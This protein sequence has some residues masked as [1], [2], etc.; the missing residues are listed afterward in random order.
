MMIVAGVATAATGPTTGAIG[1]AEA[2]GAPDAIGAVATAVIGAPV[3]TGAA[4][5]VATVTGTVATGAGT[6]H[7]KLPPAVTP[8]GTTTMK[9]V[10]SGDVMGI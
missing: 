3:A 6:L 10:P 2:T 1:A 7:K 9:G 5:G 4:T 8:L